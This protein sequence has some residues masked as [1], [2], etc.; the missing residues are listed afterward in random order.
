MDLI[1]YDY[2]GYGISPNEASEDAT[3]KDIEAVLSF[4]A[5]RL[6][7]PLNKVI[8]CGFSLGS[9]PTVEMATRFHSIP[10]I[11]L[12][13]P[14]A[15]CLSVVTNGKGR[16]DSK[17][18]MYN[19]VSKMP[20][21][22]CDVLL[23]HG[24]Q[25]KTISHTHSKELL[26]AYSDS[27]STSYNK[28]FLLEIGE[29]DHQDLFIGLELENSEYRASFLSCFDELIV[30]NHIQFHRNTVFMAR[31]R[32]NDR[33]ADTKKYEESYKDTFKEKE[34]SVSEEVDVSAMYDSLRINDDDDDD[35]DWNSSRIIA[36]SVDDGLKYTVVEQLLKHETEYLRDLYRKMSVNTMPKKWKEIEESAAKEE[37]NSDFL[38]FRKSIF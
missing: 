13:A 24:Q 23:V 2:A 27:H 7:H 12:F 28:A 11:V 22:W 29:I 30:G 37:D 17:Y 38:I 5:G 9:G 15:S 20:K 25:D 4:I 19:N 31:E 8:L 16:R 32:M 3:Y 36:G 10:F 26:K 35:E 14:L 6:N 33:K 18:D 21:I 34:S 1:I